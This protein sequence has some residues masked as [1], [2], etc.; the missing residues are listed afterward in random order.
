MI[1]LTVNG[2]PQNI[3]TS[4]DMP[5]LWAVRETLGLTGTK[6]GCGMALCGACTVHVDGAARCAS[7]VTPVSAVAGKQVTTI[8]GLSDQDRPPGPAGLDRDRRAAVRLLPVR[9]DHVGGGAARAEQRTPTD[10]GHRRGH[11]RQHLP[12]RHVPA[13]PR[14]HSPRRRARP[15]RRRVMAPGPRARSAAARLLK[16]GLAVGAGLVVG[17]RLPFLDA[18]LARRAGRRGL[19]A[20]PVAPHRPGRRR[21][22]HQLGARDGAGLA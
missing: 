13:H 9:A 11:G 8:E 17:F 1:S 2:K 18:I 3:D 21:H 15:R 7:C 12:L 6:Y 14:G 4:P 10:A 5:L 16:G 22:H 19:R 20:Q